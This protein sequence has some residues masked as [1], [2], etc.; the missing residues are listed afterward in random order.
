[1]LPGPVAH[2]P[3]NALSDV[4]QHVDLE[5]RDREA[6]PERP[7]GTA[8]YPL[9][10]GWFSRVDVRGGGDALAFAGRQREL[11]QRDIRLAGEERAFHLGGSNSLAQQK[12]AG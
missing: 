7:D 11:V 6:E 3:R 9:N 8:A 10:D 1:M 4:M 12:D 5:G 2:R